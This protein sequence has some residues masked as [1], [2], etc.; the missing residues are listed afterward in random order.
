MEKRRNVVSVKF[1]DNELEMIDNYA[2]ETNRMRSTY[3]R[4]VALGKTPR[5]RPPQDFYEILKQLR[6]I[7]NSLNQIA[8]KANKFGFID[9]L[10]YREEV[11]KMNSFILD[12]KQKYLL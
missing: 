6:Y 11:E 7:S 1:S 9:E 5:Q 3:I 12:V 10:R 4:E 8:I 2:Y